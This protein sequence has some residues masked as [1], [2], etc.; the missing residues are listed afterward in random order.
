MGQE[1]SPSTRYGAPGV[2]AEV[3]GVLR[4]ASDLF[5]EGFFFSSAEE[6]ILLVSAS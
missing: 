1:V 3:S 4:E 2:L 6:S 5:L